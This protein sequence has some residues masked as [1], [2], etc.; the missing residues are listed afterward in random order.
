MAKVVP[1]DNG[2]MSKIT[3]F[4]NLYKEGETIYVQSQ[5]KKDSLEN[6]FLYDGGDLYLF[7]EETTI[8][9]PDKD[10]KVSAFSYAIA[11]Y[12]NSIEKYNDEKDE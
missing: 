3:R 1:T 2:K 5:G 11:T 12:K 4:S 6:A 10:Y 8:V 9:L 7:L